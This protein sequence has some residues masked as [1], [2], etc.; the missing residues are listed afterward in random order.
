LTAIC[1]KK[2]NRNEPGDYSKELL[3]LQIEMIEHKLLNSGE[4]ESVD[5]MIYRNI[6]VSCLYSNEKEILAEFIQKYSDKVI[7]K[8]PEAIEIYSNSI[9][10]F[11]NADFKKCLE[12]CSK[13]NFG[14]IFD[15]ARE[16]FWFKNDIKS[17]E[18]KCFY[19]LGLF[20]NIITSG[21]S[22]NHFL[23]NTKLMNDLFREKNINFNKYLKELVLLKIDNDCDGIRDLGTKVSSLD[24]IS[25]KTWLLNKVE[26]A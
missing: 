12:C 10:Y 25:N 5:I 19:E 8:D 4:N 21:D 26:A 9:L 17:L 22:Y 13:L 24:N 14:N 15:I 6:L 2:S 11:I 18:L 3:S 7:T 23:S 16:S 20:E 1:L